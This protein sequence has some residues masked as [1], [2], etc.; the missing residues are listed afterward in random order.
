MLIVIT[1]W[2]STG[3]EARIIEQ[4]SKYDTTM[5]HVRKPGYTLDDMRQ[6]LARF[7]NKAIRN[8]MLHQHHQ[9]SEN[10]PVAG[11]H[12]KEKDKKNVNTSFWNPNL[13]SSAAYH[14]L[15]LAQHQTEFD[16]CLLSPVF[17]SISKSGLNGEKF[18]VKATNKP[19]I[20]LGGVDTENI[21]TTRS[22][23]FQGVAVL[24]ALWYNKNPFE[25]FKSI[26]KNYK[27]AY[28]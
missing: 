8:M 6:W 17:D 18:H 21:S 2:K 1:H 9:L 13:K 11:L 4:I 24:G 10:F 26:E 20:A 23:G 7:S 14:D 22:L 27:K 5:I 19:I 3:D 12:F 15:T 25:A 16:Y 28:E